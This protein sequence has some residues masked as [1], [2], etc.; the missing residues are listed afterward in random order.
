LVNSIELFWIVGEYYN[1]TAASI[2]NL[3]VE[4]SKALETKRKLVAKKKALLGFWRFAE[5]V[6]FPLHASLG[7]PSFTVPGITPKAKH[8]ISWF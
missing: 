8:N 4:T 1:F 3:H 7:W 6:R 5:T 2:G